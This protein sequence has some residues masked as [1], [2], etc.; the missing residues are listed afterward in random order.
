MSGLTA[1]SGEVLAPLDELAAEANRR[2]GL[3]ETSTHTALEHAWHAG[4]ALID[5]KAQ[6][7]HGEW[8]GWLEQN[9]AGAH[10]TAN[11][12]MAFRREI[13]NSQSTAN[14]AA[15]GVDGVLKQ[16]RTERRD[17]K[18]EA[19][20][21]QN[22]Q[23]V[24]H[25]PSLASV[26][27]RFPTIMLDPPWDWGDEGDVD[28][29]GRAKPTY[30]TMPLEELAAQPIAQLA[31]PD[32]HLYLWI[33]NRSLPKGF[34]LLDAWGF[35]YVTT[36]TWIKP[37]FGMGNYFRGSTEHVLFGV[38]GSLSLLRNDV[39]THF[40]AP[41]TARHS[42]KPEEFYELVETCSPGPWFEWP[43]R[44]RRNGWVVSGAEV[45]ERA[46]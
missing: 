26:G 37:S 45:D 21:D 42:Q 24:E 3:Y 31:E 27:E 16:L 46:A 1:V 43:A 4:Q 13:P 23:L 39:G 40:A 25:A 38:R 22:R 18:R 41:R 20:R 17:G 35:R 12:Y 15:G 28:Q 6:L 8:A 7:K 19:K 9:F 44:Q 10:R 29:M 32:A 14:L 33:T 11:D 34:G 2:H 36:L 30:A 5:A